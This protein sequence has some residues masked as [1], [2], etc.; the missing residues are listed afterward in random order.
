MNHDIIKVGRVKFKVREFRTANGK[1]NILNDGDLAE[2]KETREVESVPEA[3][4]NEMC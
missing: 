4:M 1:F 3:D 2:F